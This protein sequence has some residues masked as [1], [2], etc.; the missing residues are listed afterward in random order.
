MDQAGEKEDLDGEGQET[1]KAR[2]LFS[3]AEVGMEAELAVDRWE[4]TAEGYY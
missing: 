1:Q 3:R 2:K 4:E